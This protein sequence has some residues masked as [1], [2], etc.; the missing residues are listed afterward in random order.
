MVT[1]PNATRGQGGARQ[2]PAVRQPSPL[3]IFSPDGQGEKVW[4][5]MDLGN[6]KHAE[7]IQS[8][9]IVDKTTWK[10]WINRTFVAQHMFLSPWSKTDEVTGEYRAGFRVSLIDADG[11]VLSGAGFAFIRSL[12]RIMTIPAIGKPPWIPGLPLTVKADNYGDNAQTYWVCV[13]GPEL[14]RLIEQHAAKQSA[15]F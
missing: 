11:R 12:E 10:Q 2:L 7:L 15:P 5:T 9:G 3:D 8:L 14:A 6:P 13:P 1:E 4:H